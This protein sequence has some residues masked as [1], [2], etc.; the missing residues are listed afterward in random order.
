MVPLSALGSA[1]R[2]ARQGVLHPGAG[3]G[4]TLHD[5]LDVFLFFTLQ[6]TEEVLQLRHREGV[7]LWGGRKEEMTEHV[8]GAFFSHS[9][10]TYIDF[11]SFI[12][13]ENE[14]QDFLIGSSIQPQTEGALAV[15][16]LSDV[17]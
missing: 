9:V 12:L 5:L 6:N 10:S 2:G 13:F 11:S 7:P 1:R 16:Q 4:V 14:T 17:N 3:Q 15:R 8:W